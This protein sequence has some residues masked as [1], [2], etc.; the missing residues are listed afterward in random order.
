MVYLSILTIRNQLNVNISY[1]DPIG[2]NNF[3]LEHLIFAPATEVLGPATNLLQN[4]CLL[5]TKESHSIGSSYNGSN[6]GIF[7]Q[8]VIDE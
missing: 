5:A 3:G 1:M 7:Q 8:D 4:P 6:L 2:T